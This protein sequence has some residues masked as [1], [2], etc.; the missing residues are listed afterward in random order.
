MRVCGI[1]DV[2]PELPVAETIG[3]LAGLGGCRGGDD[4]VHVIGR[5][6]LRNDGVRLEQRRDRTADEYP[7]PRQVTQCARNGRNAGD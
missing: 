7:P 1:G 6:D 5:T 3:E 2:L 4:G